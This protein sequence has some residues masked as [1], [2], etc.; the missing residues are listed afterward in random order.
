MWQVSRLSCA[1]G[2]KRSFLEALVTS[3]TTLT[4]WCRCFSQE[5]SGSGSVGGFCLVLV[6]GGASPNPDLPRL[7]DQGQICCSRMELPVQF[8]RVTLMWPCGPDLGWDLLFAVTVFCGEEGVKDRKG[9]LESLSWRTGWISSLEALPPQ[10]CHT[11]SCT[12]FD[13]VSQF[14]EPNWLL[15][16]GF[17]MP[18]LLA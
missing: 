4:S 1:P 18:A 7:I 8:C 3:Q 2:K 13:F 6:Q 5:L 16:R 10:L 14:V 17:Q 9:N 11:P 15:T 12:L